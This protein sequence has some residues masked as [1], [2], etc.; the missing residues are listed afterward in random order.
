M[1]HP[2][3]IV[4]LTHNDKTAPN[5]KEIFLSAKDAP[6]TFWGFKDEGLS[7]AEMKELVV[8]MKA[9]G[10]ITF[11]ECLA[12]DEEKGLAAAKVAVECG[13]DYM[14][15]SLYFDSIGEYTE[16]HGMKYLPFIGDQRGAT[17]YGTLEEIVADAVATAR[18]KVYGVDLCGYRWVGDP[19]QL[20][21]AVCKAVTEETGKPV[22][23]VGSVDSYQRLDVMKSAGLWAFS[24]GGAFFED[25]FGEGFSRQIAVVDEYLKK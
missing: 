24:I 9:A 10:K 6:A 11:V 23:C 13:F 21:P 7:V 20:I 25:K 16:A 4:M 19:E 5:S 3:L 8:L 15:G 17:L 18:K 2:E 14:M 1:A 12:F 22:C